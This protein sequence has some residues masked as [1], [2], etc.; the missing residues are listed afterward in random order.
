MENSTAM[1]HELGEA[2]GKTQ[3]LP[4]KNEADGFIPVHWISH[5]NNS[6]GEVSTP[7]FDVADIRYQSFNMNSS[8]CIPPAQWSHD[9]E[10]KDL[11]FPD[12]TVFYTC[13]DITEQVRCLYRPDLQKFGYSNDPERLH[14]PGRFTLQEHVENPG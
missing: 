14:E 7:V 11:C 2:K 8:E 4:Y 5:T 9:M 6:L 13:K 3:L 1:I 12:Y 10:M